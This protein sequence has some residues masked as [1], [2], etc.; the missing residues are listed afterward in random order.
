MLKE[1]T[2]TILVDNL[3][4]EGLAVEHGCDDS[5]TTEVKVR[6]PDGLLHTRLKALDKK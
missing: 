1:V 5:P 6:L 2:I 4:R 3:A